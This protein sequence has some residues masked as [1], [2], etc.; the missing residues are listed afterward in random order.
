MV[1]HNQTQNMTLNCKNRII[2]T[3]GWLCIHK[4]QV[5]ILHIT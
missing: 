2:V 4:I 3:C 5:P 1:G